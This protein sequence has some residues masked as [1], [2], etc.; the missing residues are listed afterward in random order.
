MEISIEFLSRH[1]DLIQPGGVTKD[2]FIL[3]L[4]LFKN[5]YGTLDDR[6]VNVSSINGSGCG[7]QE[8]LSTVGKCKQLQYLFLS[9][10]QIKSIGKI[11][12]FPKLIKL[13]LQNNQLTSLGF[14]SFWEKLVDLRFLYLNGNNITNLQDINIIKDLQQL[15]VLTLFLNPIAQQNNY[16]TT[17]VDIFPNL[18]VLDNMRLSYSDQIGNSKYFV[19]RS[20]FEHFVTSQPDLFKQQ[21]KSQHIQQIVDKFNSQLKKC[22]MINPDLKD[23][24]DLFC[25]ENFNLFSSLQD[26]LQINKDFKNCPITMI[27]KCSRGYFARKRLKTFDKQQLPSITVIQRELR[28][29]YAFILYNNQIKLRVQA[30]HYALQIILR[31]LRE[32]KIVRQY[33][34]DQLFKLHQ[35]MSRNII[36][37]ALRKRKLVRTNTNFQK[38]VDDFY[39]EPYSLHLFVAKTYDDEKSSFNFFQQICDFL[40]DEISSSLSQ[41][42]S[43][44]IQNYKNVNFEFSYTKYKLFNYKILQDE[45]N[46]NKDYCIKYINPESINNTISKQL[47]Q[48]YNIEEFIQHKTLIKALKSTTNKLKNS[49]YQKTKKMLFQLDMTKS[50]ELAQHQASE[51]SDQPYFFLVSFKQKDVVCL[52]KYILQEFQNIKWSQKHKD[53][54]QYGS[55]I[56]NKLLAAGPKNQ[57]SMLFENHVIPISLLG[58]QDQRSKLIILEPLFVR[59]VSSAVIIQKCFRMHQSNKIQTTKFAQLLNKDSIRVH[60]LLLLQRA[61][62]LIQRCFRGVLGRIKSLIL[63]RMRDSFTSALQN[64]FFFI[65]EETLNKLRTNPNPA[66]WLQAIHVNYS[67]PISQQF[68]NQIFKDQNVDLQAMNVHLQTNSIFRQFAS[69]PIK[70][71]NLFSAFTGQLFGTANRENE[72]FVQLKSD[73]LGS[74]P[75]TSK[76]LFSWVR[77]LPDIEQQQFEFFGAQI[78]SEIQNQQNMFL[79]LDAI[80]SMCALRN[81]GGGSVETDR[82]LDLFKLEVITSPLNYKSIVENILSNVEIIDFDLNLVPRQLQDLAQRYVQGLKIIRLPANQ[83]IHQSDIAFKALILELLFCDPKNLM[84]DTFSFIARKWIFITN[85]GVTNSFFTLNAMLSTI[86]IQKHIRA[87]HA[88]KQYRQMPKNTTLLKKINMLFDEQ[89]QVKEGQLLAAQRELAAINLIKC[90]QQITQAVIIPT[91]YSKITSNIQI[92]TIPI[93][94]VPPKMLITQSKIL[95]ATEVRYHHCLLLAAK[96]AKRDILMNQNKQ[97]MQAVHELTQIN[98]Q[99]QLEMI[100]KPKKLLLE[101]EQIIQ[102]EVQDGSLQDKIRSNQLSS[103]VIMAPKFVI[104]EFQR[105]IIKSNIGI[106]QEEQKNIIL[107]DLSQSQRSITSPI[108]LKEQQYFKTQVLKRQLEDGVRT[109]TSQVADRKKLDCIEFQH[110]MIKKQQERQE[111]MRQEQQEISLLAEKR[112]L[113]A[114]QS[115][116]KL[117]IRNNALSS[118]TYCRGLQNMLK[119]QQ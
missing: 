55:F 62:K 103:R 25:L 78:S 48:D 51:Y 33:E 37:Q 58:K 98:L 52:L 4:S 5:P 108:S 100:Q 117:N 30:K 110:N 113:E 31:F 43:S 38:I 89:S 18:Q 119:K 81:G 16:F 86:T 24:H 54:L 34:F 22:E 84:F 1:S 7:L 69:L 101:L 104:N 109:T 59:S 50:S 14:R 115:K 19:S 12:V 75:L 32:R 116:K 44:D 97:K 23:Y 15:I 88:R 73:F 10:N 63:N 68:A 47:T 11:N 27:Q 83:H 40:K 118:L 57:I 91:I 49:I 82:L 53:A 46:L 28:A 102:Q 61:A 45:V 2:E 74:S 95:S 60:Q 107:P 20:K 93:R 90:A 35:I 80:K 66:H 17:I 79:D 41:H 67:Y 39:N 29:S 71:S 64:Q 96:E 9:N 85:P 72:G 6:L 3:Y 13:D 106:T 26:A 94:V 21:Y 8:F 105:P 36:I 77:H 42:S 114:I 70:V 111:K 87:Y 112:K 56:F 65:H 92:S 99:K 76:A